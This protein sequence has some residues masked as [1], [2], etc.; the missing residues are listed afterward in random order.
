MKQYNRSIAEA[1]AY[2]L[3][4]QNGWTDLLLQPAKVAEEAIEL[5]KACTTEEI[6]EECADVLFA[7][8]SISQKLG[9]TLDQLLDIAIEKNKKRLTDPNYMR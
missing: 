7:L 4:E 5:S 3:S 2:K 6:V 8:N 9:Y 1:R